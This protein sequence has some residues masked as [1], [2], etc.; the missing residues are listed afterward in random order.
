MNDTEVQAGLRDYYQSIT[1]GDSVRASML[2]GAAIA[3]KRR[4][5][6]PRRWNNLR[7]LSGVTAAVAVALVVGIAFA[8]WRVGPNGSPPGGPT[9]SATTGPVASAT[10]APKPSPTLRAPTS[11]TPAGSFSPTGSM[12]SRY[13]AATLLLDGRVLMTGD[14]ALT[15]IEGYQVPIY[16]TAAELYDPATGTFAPTGSMI[17]AQG[18]AT[19]TRLAD[20]RVLFAGG[21]QAS[22]TGGKLVLTSLATAELYDP[23][24]GT[25]ASTGSLTRPRA[26]HA[27][28]LLNS[29][30]VLIAGGDSPSGDKTAELYDPATGTFT[31][32]GD[33]TMGRA[34]SKAIALADGRVLI[35]GDS[36]GTTVTKTAELYD[37]S[38]GTFS[39]TGSMT[40]MRLS[41]SVTL[42]RDGRVLVASGS[43]PM[44]SSTSSAELFDPASGTFSPAGSFVEDREVTGATLLLDGRVLF[45]G[46]IYSPYGIHLQPTHVAA[47]AMSARL[48]R[49]DV[50]GPGWASS[51]VAATPAAG[52][53]V[54]GSTAPSIT[55]SSAELYDPTTGQFIM[56]GSMGTPRAGN[57]ATLLL[58]GR[59]LIAGGDANGLTAE[60]YQP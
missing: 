23:A 36:P 46:G 13:S 47:D 3:S 2:V 57:T 5:G 30:E 6:V 8:A 4:R 15:T 51:G 18:G 43:G 49:T 45:A 11:S 29:G 38:T 55:R 9:S 27:A 58:D 21:T 52:P 1:P 33:M 39:R 17:Q 42:L 32:T 19:V 35:L 7:L 28:T 24:T 25:F 44:D 20:G 48:G 40:T 53:G 16:S 12:N 31:R 14:S 22:D 26:D 34:M 54:R 59:V 56:T 41:P 50:I 10:I 60:L 37:P